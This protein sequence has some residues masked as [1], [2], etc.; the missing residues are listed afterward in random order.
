LEV[1][2]AVRDAIARRA[3][4]EE[5]RAIAVQHGMRTLAVDGIMKALEGWTT[6]EEVLRVL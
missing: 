5:L 3:S 6:V 1:G 4:T 2:P